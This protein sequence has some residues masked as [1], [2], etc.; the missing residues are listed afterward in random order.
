MAGPGEVFYN[1]SSFV[2][3]YIMERSQASMIDSAIWSER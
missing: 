3:Q 2:L 1:V